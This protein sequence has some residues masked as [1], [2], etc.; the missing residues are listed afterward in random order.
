MTVLFPLLLCLDPL[1]NF[2]LSDY[3]SYSIRI[4]SLEG[5]L[6]HT[7]RS[8]EQE[9]GRFYGSKGVVITPN[10]EISLCVIVIIPVYK[11]FLVDLC[12]TLTN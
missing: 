2:V 5:N 11:Y 12:L 6:L 10:G 3:K 8:D 1:N 7:M 4:F 9:R